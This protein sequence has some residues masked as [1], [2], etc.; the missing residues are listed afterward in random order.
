MEFTYRLHSA[1]MPLR[2]MGVPRVLERELVHRRVDVLRGLRVVQKV[3]KREDIRVEARFFRLHKLRLDWGRASGGARQKERT[4]FYERLGRL[5]GVEDA[6][7]E[8]Y[9]VRV[10]LN[11]AFGFHT[12]R[13]SAQGAQEES[14]QEV[15]RPKAH[16]H[17]TR[18]Y[19]QLAPDFSDASERTGNIMR[20]SQIPM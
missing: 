12:C 4:A 5:G 20:K 8:S 19:A 9:V 17:R 1:D 16:R 3:R 13:W 6:V 11:G 10:G 7:E 18:E 15:V 14:E 2:R